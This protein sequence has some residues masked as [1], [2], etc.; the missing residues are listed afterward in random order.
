MSTPPRYTLYGPGF[1]SNPFP[2]YA[3]MRRDEPIC[4]HPGI[5]GEGQLWFITRYDDVQTVLRDHTTFVKS[6]RATRTP[7]ELAQ[8]GEESPLLQL[9]DGH[10]LNR[11][12]ADHARLRA[13]V[14]KAFTARIVNLQRERVQAVADQ[15]LD[16]V[17]ANGQMDLIDDFAFPLPI[18]VILEMLGIPPEDRER[19]R[20]WSNAFVAPSLTEEAW[21]EAAVL[22][23]EFTDY[24]RGIFAQR[25][26][27]PQN[28]L[29]TGLVQAEEAGDRLTEAEL[30]AMV[31]LLIVAGH[32]TTVNLIGN[33]V[34]AL[35]DHPEQMAHLRDHPEAMPTAVEEL[36]RYAGPVDR[37]T[38]RFVA[39]DTEF[40]GHRMRRGDAVLPVLLSANRDE[41]HFAA[42][43]ALD[44]RRADRGHLAFG[45]GVHYC[46]GAPLARMEGTIALN[47]LLR[48]LPGL[49]LATDRAGLEWTT[50]PLFYGARHI[51]LAW[52]TDQ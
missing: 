44:I 9:L 35:L 52:E 45:H 11:D 39:L 25:R 43:D 40:R 50:V 26:A 37:A 7:D 28:D 19:F 24:L 33:S 20:D 31:V 3:A 2:T 10:M 22:L 42:P 15:L 16:R 8:L 30:F 38:T 32:E 17:Q 6:W 41:T 4:Y 14:N 48:R 46:V 23:T 51:P 5:T 1:K 34:L 12:G 21:R 47:T 18:V 49:R 29:I 36:L 13:L 27:A